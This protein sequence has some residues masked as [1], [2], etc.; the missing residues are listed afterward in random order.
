MDAPSL[1]DIGPNEGELDYLRGLLAA[2]DAAAA[3]IEFC[4]EGTIRSANSGFL[5]VMGYRMEDIRGRHHS[6]FVDPTEA[7]SDEYQRFWSE[8]RAGRRTSAKITRIRSDGQ[9]VLLQ[10]VY[11][12][13]RDAAGDV[14]GVVKIAQ[15]ITEQEQRARREAAQIEAISSSHAVIEFS[16]DGIVLSANES[17]V[18]MFGYTPGEVVGRHHRIFM[19]PE[20][21][22]RPAYTTFWRELG[23]G[24]A[25]GG[26]FRRLAKGERVVWL[27]AQYSPVFGPDGRVESVTKIATD[28]TDTVELRRRAEVLSLVANETSNSVVIADAMGRIEYVNPGFTGLTGYTFEEVKGRKPGDVLQGPHTNSETVAHI[29]ERLRQ[30]ERFYEEILNYSK[31]GVSYWI[32]LAIN[33]VKDA[34]GQVERFVSIQAEITDTKREAL[35]RIAQLEA[36]GAEAALVTWKHW[37]A[38]PTCSPF[39]TAF[40]GARTDVRIFELLEGG[41]RAALERG[42]KVQKT[43]QWPCDGEISL[44][45]D[46]L[47]ATSENEEGRLSEIVLFGSDASAR[48]QSVRRTQSSLEEVMRSSEEISDALAVIDDIASQTNLLALNATIEAARAGEAGKGFGVVAHEVKDL[49]SRSS[50]SAR[51]IG[52]C[53][54][55]NEAT[56]GRLDEALSG[57]S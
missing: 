16:P 14:L 6:I 56:V 30:G 49:A 28:I 26:E 54:E 27:H 51:R 55:Q 52:E 43:V 57:L 38:S 10:A 32:S 22:S 45:L 24:I 12:P 47:I 11:Q 20:D 44:W 34:S 39:L 15:D 7:A 17:F 9:R 53:L 29:R 5:E 2:L 46:V 35:R 8:L 41:E 18:H 3:R 33:P 42:E 36:I 31:S 40:R 4:P 50:A 1:A 37:D 13:I 25:K 48:V 21:A 19:E 23:E